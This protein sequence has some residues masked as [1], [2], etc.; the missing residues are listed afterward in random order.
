MRFAAYRILRF[1]VQEL[2][3]VAGRE[4]GIYAAS[5]SVI[6]LRLKQPGLWYY[7]ALK[8]HKCRAPA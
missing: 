8:R 4:R 7:R 3:G 5:T 1:H 6:R 2:F